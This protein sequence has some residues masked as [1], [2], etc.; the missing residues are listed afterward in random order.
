MSHHSAQIEIHKTQIYSI[1][2]I[3]YN[4]FIRISDDKIDELVATLPYSDVFELEF[5]ISRLIYLNTES[6][7]QDDMMLTHLID[8]LNKGATSGRE[9]DAQE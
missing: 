9:E 5:I 6:S 7:S 1:T 2:G 8:V 4:D 3:E